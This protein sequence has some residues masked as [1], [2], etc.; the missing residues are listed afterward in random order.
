MDIS[1]P[2]R[3]NILS[4]LSPTEFYIDENGFKRTPYNVPNP[5][6]ECCGKLSSEIDLY[7]WKYIAIPNSNE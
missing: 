7:W 5:I 4:I 6:C 3:D 1:L 2:T